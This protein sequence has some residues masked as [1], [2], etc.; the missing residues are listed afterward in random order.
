[1]LIQGR[2]H[3]P[4]FF[5]WSD[6]QLRLKDDLQEKKGVILSLLMPQGALDVTSRI[7]V[8]ILTMENF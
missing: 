3:D 2:L 4:K 6:V 7:I 1:M 5:G 8:I